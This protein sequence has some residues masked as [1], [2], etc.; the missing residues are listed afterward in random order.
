MA[1]MPG[2]RKHRP[3]SPP[4]RSL[5]PEPALLSGAITVRRRLPVYEAAIVPP[6]V[7]D[8]Y[9]TFSGL[10][11]GSGSRRDER[12]RFIAIS[13][14][15]SNSASYRLPKRNRRPYHLYRS[16]WHFYYQRNNAILNESAPSFVQLDFGADHNGSL[17]ITTVMDVSFD[18]GKPPRTTGT[19]TR[20]G[21]LT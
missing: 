8:D 3:S 14:S 20:F 5:C 4:D 6:A 1:P 16:K 11:N 19:S 9:E 12:D 13:G 21:I 17:S 10:C 2:I 18:S 7:E 15:R